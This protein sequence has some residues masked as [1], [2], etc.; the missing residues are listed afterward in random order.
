MS[1]LDLLGASTAP[2]LLVR[3]LNPGEVASK[4]GGYKGTLAAALIPGTT[5]GFVLDE[6]AAQLRQELASEGVRAEVEIVTDPAPMR[7]ATVRS[8]LIPGAVLGA[9]LAG[10]AFY[11]FGRATK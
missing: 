9:G 7:A 1:A 6:I 4:R 8:D 5:S 11:L 10:V 3:V 2:A